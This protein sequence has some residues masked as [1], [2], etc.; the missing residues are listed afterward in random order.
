MATFT[1]A[2]G[3]PKS[4]IYHSDLVYLTGN[5]PATIVIRSAPTASTYKNRPPYVRLQVP[6]DDKEYKLDIEHA[7]IQQVL[8][9]IPLNTPVQVK[10]TGKGDEA[11]L[12]VF[13]QS[14]ATSPQ[15]A[16]PQQQQAPA[17]APPPNT[18]PA[19][20]P[21]RELPPMTRAYFH[22]FMAAHE[23]A[24]KVLHDCGDAFARITPGERLEFTHSVATHFSIGLEHNP[25]RPLRAVKNGN[26]HAPAPP[27]PQQQPD[28]LGDLPF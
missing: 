7:G 19:Y 3:T 12:V 20:V 2:D 10:A 24:T 16:A 15:S 5:G 22:C 18:Q 17:A 6:P 11:Q 28:P 4:G 13:G 26:G 23:V 1:K 27:A 21:P 9:S 25:D 14:A 8:V